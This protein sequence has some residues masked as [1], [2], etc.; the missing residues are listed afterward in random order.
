ML[1]MRAEKSSS[2]QSFFFIFKKTGNTEENKFE[3]DYVMK[4]NLFPN[5]KTIVL[6]A[7]V[8]CF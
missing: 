2:G 3:I 1:S 8:I 4:W 5:R 7:Q 6:L